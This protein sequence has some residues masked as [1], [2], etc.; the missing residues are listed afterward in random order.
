LRSK[1]REIKP[2][3]IEW[4]LENF[5]ARVESDCFSYGGKTFRNVIGPFVALN[6]ILSGQRSWEGKKL[7]AYLQKRR[8]NP[9]T[10]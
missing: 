7:S 3:A 6:W 5:G 1:L 9:D 2:A 10:H 8:S 4:K